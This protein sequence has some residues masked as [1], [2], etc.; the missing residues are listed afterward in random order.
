VLTAGMLCNERHAT[1]DNPAP[2][3]SPA[4]HCSWGGSWVLTA[5]SRDGEGRGGYTNKCHGGYMNKHHVTNTNPAPTPSTCH[6]TCE[7]L[8]TGWVT[9]A[10][11]A[12][13]AERTKPNKMN[14]M[15]HPPPQH[16]PP[17]LQAT[18]RR[19]G[20]RCYRYDKGRTYKNKC[21]EGRMD[22]NKHNEG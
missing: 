15:T 12:T 5:T 7:P 1:N 16:L 18:P 2:T 13:R 14:K 19:V 22:E 11:N 17:R 4:S 3:P 8:L 10:T 9:G 20:N 21:N 6:H